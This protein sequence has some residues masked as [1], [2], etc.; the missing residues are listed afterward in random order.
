MTNIDI[1]TE[2]L[3]GARRGGELV[4]T[5]F[6]IAHP[7]SAAEAMQVQE[8]VVKAIGGVGAWKVAPSST[9][10]QPNYGPI[11]A[12]DIFEESHDF[13]AD[14]FR[15]VGAECEIAYR[16]GRDLTDG[17]YTRDQVADAI[18]VLMPLIE[19]TE[20]R[21]ADRRAATNV[22]WHLADGGANAAL[23]IG[24]PVSD[25]KSI[26]TRQ[27]PVTLSYDGAEVGGAEGNP[28]PDLVA[29]V[30]LLVN[31]A[32][33]HCG[34]VRAGQIVTTGGMFGNFP[35]GSATNVIASFHNLGD[36]RAN[37]G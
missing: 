7:L 2:R 29:I 27:Q 6:I 22:N 14:R 1:A 10:E 9:S 36:I 35:L 12:K 20:S 30:E 11:F 28:R 33:K 17:P 4:P 3:L 16:I 37:F 18:D 25:W 24:R 23:L 31:Q 34:G 5:D 15:F 8:N 13:G 26:N 21:L 32:G 19:V